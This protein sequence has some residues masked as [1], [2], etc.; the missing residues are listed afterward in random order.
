[1]ATL[2]N[3][4]PMQAKKTSLLM[5]LRNAVEHKKVTA[6]K[7]HPSRDN[8]EHNRSIRDMVERALGLRSSGDILKILF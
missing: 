7:V 4:F 6:I 8:A 2:V 5:G 3:T 1:V